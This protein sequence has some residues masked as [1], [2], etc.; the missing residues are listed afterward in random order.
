MNFQ[1]TNHNMHI[2][3]FD[4]SYTKTL[5]KFIKNSKPHGYIDW[6]LEYNFFKN[7][8]ISKNN[9]TTKSFILI[10]SD[11]SKQVISGYC[12][13]DNKIGLGYSQLNIFL[14]DENYSN[15][16]KIINYLKKNS[17]ITTKKLVI[18][19]N[20]EEKKLQKYL[21]T[22][23]WRVVRKFYKL[24]KTLF[25]DS[26]ITIDNKF[27][28]IRIEEKDSS[29]LAKLQNDAFKS[30]WGYEK[31]TP[32]EI[33]KEITKK[34]NTILIH[35]NQSQSILGYVWIMQTQNYIS[36]INMLGIDPNF[37]GNG[38][39]KSLLY[40]ALNHEINNG[41]KRVILD[42]DSRN[43]KA[44]KLYEKFGFNKYLSLIWWEKEL[45]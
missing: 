6:I 20:S 11:Q 36:K 35:K 3:N 13:I 17:K 26:N 38:L 15:I 29:K 40:H 43:I 30:H 21:L 39:G 16:T 9:N 25:N 34:Y 22:C 1:K 37:T 41:K 7:S 4:K 45:G 19:S 33:T 5:Y 32:S 42:V 14:E 18:A 12:L 28:I 8:L 23:D 31:N 10:F 44:C 24:E 2:T 27:N